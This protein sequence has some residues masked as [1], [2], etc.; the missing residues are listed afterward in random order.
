VFSMKA[1]PARPFSWHVVSTSR[2]A[3]KPRSG[4]RTA[5]LRPEHDPKTT[6]HAAADDHGDVDTDRNTPRWFNP[7]TMRT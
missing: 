7:I 5:P 1:L 4:N 6:R 2:I 3:S